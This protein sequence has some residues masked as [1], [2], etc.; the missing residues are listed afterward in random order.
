MWTLPADEEIRAL[1]IDRIDV[2]RRG[3]GVVVGVIDA[4]GRRIIAHGAASRTDGQAVNGDTVFAIGSVTK[5]FTSL[6]LADM[7]QIGDVAL[8][9]PVSDYLPEG[10]TAPVRDGRGI[11]LIDLATHTSGLPFMDPD[12]RTRDP[13]HPHALAGQAQALAE[14]TVGRMYR[15]LSHY[16]LPRD[17]GQ[18]FEYS[19]LG[20]G[21]LGHALA[22]R[23]GID[24]ETLVATR[25]TRPLGM[26]STVITLPDSLKSRFA[27]GHDRELRPVARLEVSAL[28][29][30]GALCS[31]ANDLLT[32]LA[33]ELAFDETPLKAAISA[34][35]E[36]RRPTQRAQTE[37]ALGWYVS[38]TRPG[39]IVWHTGGTVGSATFLGFDLA[40]RVGV[41]VLANSHSGDNLGLYMLA[42]LPLASTRPSA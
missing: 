32:F 19:N 37:T 29:G 16:S 4:K 38:I 12:F 26:S 41:V 7:A 2:R 42:S 17:V 14:Y 31:T 40:R 39:E 1:L 10:V 33:A 20:A 36:P 13:E 22:L 18:R 3:V 8:T 30:A 9:D 11:T 15:F 27:T 28:P 21:L 6:L 24:Y 5:V 25:I 35:L 23:A 34:Q